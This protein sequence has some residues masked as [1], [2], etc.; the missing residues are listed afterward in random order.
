VDNRLSG[1]TGTIRM[2]GVFPN[3]KGGL[4][5]GLFARVRLPIGQP[6]QAT[7]IPDEA[8]QSDQG[9]KFV[10]V[11]NGQSTV[12]YRPVELG[13]EIHGLRV[14]KKGLAGGERVIVSGMQ[15]V[16]P[17]AEVQVKTQ[18]PPQPPHASLGK[19]LKFDRPGRSAT[20]GAGRPGAEPARPNG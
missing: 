12:E 13:Q 19:L 4:K 15:R 3:P 14:I 17:K 9:R 7:L 18:P 16:R 8:V 2:R 1:N 5:A 6:Y 10:Y 11:V 20:T